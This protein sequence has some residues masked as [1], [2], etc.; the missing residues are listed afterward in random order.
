[1]KRMFMLFVFVMTAVCVNAQV[2]S[3]GGGETSLDIGK[4]YV[5]DKGEEHTSGPGEYGQYE[6]VFKGSIIEAGAGSN[7]ADVLDA[8]PGVYSLKA[9]VLNSG[10]GSYAPHVMKIRGL[11]AT[12]NSGIIVFIDGR[13]QSMAVWRHALLDTLPLDAVESVRLI[14][15]PSSVEFGNQATA[16]VIDIKTK[17]PGKDGVKTTMGAM[18]GNYY[19]QDYFV[20]NIYKRGSLDYSVAAGYKSTDG[21]RKNSDSYQQNYRGSLGYDINECWRAEINGGYSDVRAYNPGPLGEDWVREQEAVHTIQRD[22]D[23]RITHTDG[24]N[25]GRVIFYTD[26]G[27]NDFLVSSTPM[28]VTIPGS[29][30]RYENY[31]ARIMKEFSPVPGNKIKAGFDW[32]YFGGYFENYPP[33]EPMKKQEEKHENDYAP[34]V[35]VNQNVGMTGISCGLRYGMNSVWGNELIPQAALNISMYEGQ[36]FYLSASKGYRTPA[37]GTLIFENYGELK[38]E[39]F[40]QYE[41]GTTHDVG[42]NFTYSLSFYQTEGNNILQADPVDSELKNSGFILIRGAEAGAAARLFD[43]VKLGSSISYLDPREKTAGL[44]RLTGRSWLEVRPVSGIKI[45]VEALYA[46][47]RFNADNT[48]QKLD[49]YFVLNAGVDY[50]TDFMGVDTTIYLD[51]ENINDV[52]Y[53]VKKGYPVPGF[54]IKGGMAAR[55]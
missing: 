4:V 40:W 9:G 16:A 39:N 22:A 34:Y 31:G 15:G 46:H 11:G 51:M 23:I 32:Q 38:P 13:P 55:I 47:D 10:A 21:H 49:D 6:A 12:P 25:K 30:N 2:S 5:E 35:L 26:S 18:A 24:E 14:K 3:A 28:G 43:K 44:A 54:L 42:D 45:S 17:K 8:E 27:F 36:E 37:M 19:T 50:N 29:D 20:N 48:Q 1:M 41:A 33:M 52:K 7:V 53:E